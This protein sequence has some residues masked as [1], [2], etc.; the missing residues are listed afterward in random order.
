MLREGLDLPEVSLVAILDAD[1]EGFLRAERSLIQT[2]GRAARHIRGQA[3][4]Y[5]D[6]M[7]DSM[8]KAIDETERRR[9][10]Q[11]AH[12]KMHNITPKPIVKKKSSN[13]ILSFL[14][15]SR[16]LNSQDL[17]VV[18]EHVDEIPLEDIPQLVN[19]LEAQM[20]D[21][22]KNLQFEEAAKFRDRIKNLR[23]KLV[24]RS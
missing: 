17:E 20:K 5:A 6:K 15:V 12:N 13:A 7:T 21:A 16:L 22:A 14:E 19:K 18:D 23:D 1:K 8:I 2:I 9:G 10:I 4:L 11:T 3:I 24:G